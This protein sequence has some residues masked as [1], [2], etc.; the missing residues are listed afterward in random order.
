MTGDE[1]R[2]TASIQRSPLAQ[3]IASR[4]AAVRDLRAQGDLEMA[5]RIAS[6][7]KP[8]VVLWALN[9]AGAVARDDLDTL[10]DSARALESAQERVLGGDRDAA[11]VMQRAAHDQ[12]QQVDVLTRRLGMV[13]G[14]SGHAAPETT[15]RRISEGLRAASLADDE[16]WLALREGLLTEEPTAAGFPML[17]VALAPAAQAAGEQREADDQRRRFD[18]AEADVQRAATRLGS[19]R[20]SEELATRRREQAELELDVAQARLVELGR[21][22]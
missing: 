6:L 20:E 14:A 18:A 1:A 5:S 3:F 7:R 17:D 16:A 12:R 19:A 10:R 11:T 13:L 8:S 15:L 21:D 22:S 4:D 2:I 9:Q